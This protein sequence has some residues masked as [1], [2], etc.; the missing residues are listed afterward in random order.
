[1]PPYRTGDYSAFRTVDLEAILEATAPTGY[2]RRAVFDELVKR[3]S[4]MIKQGPSA[5]PY[6]A[7]G[8]PPP[9]NQQPVTPYNSGVYIPPQPSPSAR[10]GTAS[11]CLMALAFVLAVFIALYMLQSVPLTLRR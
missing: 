10:G 7:A 11:G 2:D 3:Y 8:Q 6:N 4:L 9:V 1:M 5:V